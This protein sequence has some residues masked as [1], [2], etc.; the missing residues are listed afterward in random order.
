MLIGSSFLCENSFHGLMEYTN[1]QTITL[2]KG[3][4]QPPRTNGRSR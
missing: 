1:V 3:A 2:S 4:L